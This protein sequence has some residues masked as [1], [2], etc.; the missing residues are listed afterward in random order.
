MVPRLPYQEAVSMGQF[1][2]SIQWWFRPHDGFM[3][4]PADVMTG[5]LPPFPPPD[6][7]PLG[8]TNLE[9]TLERVAADADGGASTQVLLFSDCDAHIDDPQHLIELFQRQHVTL[10]VLALGSGVG[11][12]A[13][14]QIV[15]Q[16]GRVD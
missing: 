7:V 6:A 4:P 12:P 1:S 15:A 11:V 8:P 10:H 5:E 14:R 9:E 3:R 2:D 13:I 16:N